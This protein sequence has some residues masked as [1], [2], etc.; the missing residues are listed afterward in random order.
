MDLIQGMEKDAK[1]KI[2][3]MRVDGGMTV[4]NEFIQS[5]SNILQIKNYKASKY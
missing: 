1:M 3:D 2:K 4:N 5:I